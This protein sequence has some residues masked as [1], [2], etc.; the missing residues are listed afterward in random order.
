MLARTPAHSSKSS[1][2]STFLPSPCTISLLPLTD[3]LVLFKLK[4]QLKFPVK[5][6][7]IRTAKKVLSQGFH[8]H[9][10]SSTEIFPRQLEAACAPCPASLSSHCEL[11][12]TSMSSVLQHLGVTHAFRCLVHRVREA[13]LSLKCGYSQPRHTQL[14]MQEG[15]FPY[16]GI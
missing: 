1:Q 16:Q 14:A 15:S 4:L 8:Q 3:L 6:D 12:A 11:G 2:L 5:V 13:T 9:C 10:A 7:G